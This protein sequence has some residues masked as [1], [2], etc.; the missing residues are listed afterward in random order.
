MPEAKKFGVNKVI[1]LYNGIL[2]ES[3]GIPFPNA[4]EI[5]KDAFTEAVEK[6]GENKDAGQTWKTSSGKAFEKIAIEAVLRILNKETFKGKNVEGKRWN[7]LTLSQKDDLSQTMIRRC[8]GEKTPLSNEPDITI[9]KN[10][11]PEII[12]SCKSSL[13]DRVSIDLYWATEYAKGGKKFIVV[14]AETSE[15]LGTHEK[16]K[17]SRLIAECLYERLYIVNG[18]T[19]YCKIVRPFSDL[20]KDLTTW[21][22]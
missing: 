22:E 1:Q 3:Q 9:L 15:T 13:R 21:L 10:G 8:S 4:W 14:S 19:N 6:S 16:P 11:R 20:E 2:E 5:T 17:K 12:L 18:Q 7:E